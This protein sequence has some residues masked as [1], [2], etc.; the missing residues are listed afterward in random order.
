MSQREPVLEDYRPNLANLI[1]LGLSG[2]RLK[3]DDFVDLIAGIDVVT[4]TNPF[5]KTKAMQQTP[6]LD[7]A[8]ISI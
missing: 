7:E 8:D 6:Q 1:R 5:R 4:A 3:I 2:R